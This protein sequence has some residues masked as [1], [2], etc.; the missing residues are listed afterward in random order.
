[1]PGYICVYSY[2]SPAMADLRF[3]SVLPMGS[4]VAGSPTSF[5]KSRWPKAWPVSASAVSLNSP[6]T[7]GGEIE[8]AAVRLGF[9]REGFLEVLVALAALDALACHGLSSLGSVPGGGGSVPVGLRVSGAADAG[10]PGGP[11]T[12][13]S[14][15][16]TRCGDA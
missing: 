6:A 10:G 15:R 5:R 12:A 4:P 13:D 2:V 8:V 11:G 1:M 9:A 3:V 14:G 16:R 7:S